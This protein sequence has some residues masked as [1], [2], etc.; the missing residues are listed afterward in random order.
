MTVDMPPDY[1]NLEIRTIAMPK[2]TNSRGHIFG[3]WLLSRMDLAGANAASLHAEGLVATVAINSVQFVRPV[4]VGDEV[5]CYAV[6][7]KTGKTSI[8]VDIQV[9]CRRRSGREHINV[10]TGEFVFVALD[11]VGRSRLLEKKEKTL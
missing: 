3:G 2:D 4:Y 1:R 5:S 8:T 9:W 7:K 6:V 11:D 10:A